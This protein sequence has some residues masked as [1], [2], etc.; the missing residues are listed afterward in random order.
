M[1]YSMNII[2]YYIIILLYIYVQLLV[3]SWDLME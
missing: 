2:I 3:Q 1:I